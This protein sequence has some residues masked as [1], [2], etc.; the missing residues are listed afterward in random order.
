MMM[1]GAMDVLWWYLSTLKRGDGRLMFKR[2]SNIAKLV[3]VIPHS[4]AEE[5][6]VSSIIRKIRHPILV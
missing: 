3:L 1:M 5:E 2:S 6:H 4:N